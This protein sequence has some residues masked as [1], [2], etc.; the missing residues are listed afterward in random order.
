M[1]NNFESQLDAIRIELYEQTKDLSNAEAV[2]TINVSGEKIA[3]KYGI[4]VVKNDKH[5][6][7]FSQ[8]WDTT[9]TPFSFC[10][11]II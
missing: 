7:P 6:S 4:I 11:Y 5:S 8:I 9:P 3:D 10:S 1:T 2:K